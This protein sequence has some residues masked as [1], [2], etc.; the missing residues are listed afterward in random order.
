MSAA[1]G[2]IDRSPSP[3]IAPLPR[4]AGASGP[5]R[6]PGTLRPGGPHRLIAV[7][8]TLFRLTKPPSIRSPPP[9]AV[10]L[11]NGETAVVGGEPPSIT[12]PWSSPRNK[13]TVRLVVTPLAPMISKTRPV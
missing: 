1:G 7:S 10:P 3:A 4:T 6:R 9:T 12:R 2:D 13:W 11:G 8:V 5:R